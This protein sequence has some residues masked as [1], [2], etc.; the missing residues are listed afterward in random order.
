MTLNINELPRGGTACLGCAGLGVD[1]DV[2]ED[3]E[4]LADFPFA[5][6]GLSYICTSADGD[7]K[8][9]GETV[10]DGY[11]A[12]FLVCINAAGTITV[13]KGDE[14][15]N[16]DLTAGVA[17]VHWPTPT[18]D[19]CPIGA[20]KIKNATGSQFVGGTTGLDTANITDTFYNF[21]CVPEAPL[22]S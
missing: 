12:L 2:T 1:A 18:A 5:I 15:A 22:T 8:L 6:N 20:I 14:V 3:A 4:T 10:E 17:V 21:F 11:T 19:T 9:D 16:A 13:V 7:V